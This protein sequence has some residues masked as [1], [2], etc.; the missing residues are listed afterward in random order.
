MALFYPYEVKKLWKR[1][2]EIS[3]NILTYCIHA[4]FFMYIYVILLIYNIIYMSGKSMFVYECICVVAT[5]HLVMRMDDIH[6]FWTC[7]VRYKFLCCSKPVYL[8]GMIVSMWSQ[9]C[10]NRGSAKWS[11]PFRLVKDSAEWV[12]IHG[13]SPLCRVPGFSPWRGSACI[14]F[15]FFFGTRSKKI[16][17]KKDNLPFWPSQKNSW[18][19]WVRTISWPTSHRRLAN[20]SRC[21]I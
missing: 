16:M 5:K 11:L 3:V 18:M 21:Y 19:N 7:K 13:D 15:T 1:F 4:Y 6:I 12:R 2:Q 9:F 14:L 8:Y 17:G 20:F 10:T